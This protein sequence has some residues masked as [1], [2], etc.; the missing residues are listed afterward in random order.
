MNK[1]QGK[2]VLYVTLLAVATLVIAATVM[3]LMGKQ[4]SNNTQT[5]EKTPVATESPTASP[6]PTATPNPHIG[7]VRSQLTGK[8]IKKSVDKKRCFAVMINNIEYAFRNQYGT[9]K[10]DILYEALAEGGITRMLAIYENV[11]DVKK[12]GSV[13]S[14]RHYYV[15]FADEWDA[16]YCHFGHTHYAESKMDTL[17]TNNI[18]GLSGIGPVAYSRT[19]SLV[20]PHN[21]ITNGKKLLKAAKKL[22]YRTKRKTSKMGEH[23]NFYETDTDL[24]KGKKATKITIPFSNYSTCKFKY[25]K[26]KKVYKKYEYGK[27]HMDAYYKK[28]LK[29]KNV[30]VQF[31]DQ[32]NI[33]SNGYQTMK[34]N[35]EGSGYYYTNG[36]RVKITWV[37]N[38]RKDTMEYRKTDGTLLTINPGKTYIAVYP[39][40][41]KRFVK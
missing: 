17:N 5:S 38:E 23:F 4:N 31:V 24:A 19:S 28:Q 15:Q 12:I 1:K 22:K 16:I 29:F 37:R 33:D 36:K 35:S 30:I 13:R 39:K 11:K 21:V 10:A 2:I 41:R 8:W 20:A 25:D 27:K 18:S 3:V 7:E 26:K 6:V 34:L 14:A 40:S 9:S 32:S